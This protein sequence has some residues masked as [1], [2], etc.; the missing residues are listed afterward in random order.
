MSMK[1]ILH[2]VPIFTGAQP[3]EGI[4]SIYIDGKTGD[5]MLQ[6]ADGAVA[7]LEGAESIVAQSDAVMIVHRPETGHAPESVP[8]SKLKSANFLD[9]FEDEVQKLIR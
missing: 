6:T 5:T 8:F 2:S 1:L 4:P 3:K 7:K 9:E